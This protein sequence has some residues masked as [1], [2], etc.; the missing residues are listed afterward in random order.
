[1]DNCSSFRKFQDQVYHIK[2]RGNTILKHGRTKTILTGQ[3]KEYVFV[4]STLMTG[5]V[6]VSFA[7]VFY[8]VAVITEQRKHIV[9]GV[10]LGFLTAGLGCDFTSTLYMIIGSHNIPITVHGFIGYSALCAMLVETM[11]I[12][13]H[14]RKN[15]SSTKVPRGLHNYTRIAYGWWVI[16]YIAGGIIASI[17]IKS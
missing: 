16:A 2:T 11:L 7:L 17:G 10:V 4:N 6:I 3:Q 8:S 1:L 15:R 5:V 12:W 9:S 13:G 14:W